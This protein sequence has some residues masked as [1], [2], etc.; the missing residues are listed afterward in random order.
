[1]LFTCLLAFIVYGEESAVILFYFSPIGIVSISSGF[2]HDSSLSFVFSSM[3][4]KY[5]GAFSFM[6]SLWFTETL[7][8]LE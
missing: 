2:F 8:Y 3:N 6:F 4:L 7:R 5:L 1:M